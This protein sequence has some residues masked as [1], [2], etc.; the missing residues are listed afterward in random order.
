MRTYDIDPIRLAEAIF[1]SQCG[2]PVAEAIRGT[3]VWQDRIK[4][5]CHIAVIYQ[6]MKEA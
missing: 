4:E 5:A 6:E 2:Q 3:Q 1:M